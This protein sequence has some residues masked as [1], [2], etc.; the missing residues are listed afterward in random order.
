[1]TNNN[2]EV[3]LSVWGSYSG[4]GGGAGASLEQVKTKLRSCENQVSGAKLT[5]VQV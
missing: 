3:S 5:C 4:G 1:M 2:Q